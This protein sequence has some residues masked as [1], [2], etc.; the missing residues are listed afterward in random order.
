MGLRHYSKLARGVSVFHLIVYSLRWLSF[1]VVF[2]E[3]PQR[4]C[5]TFHLTSVAYPCTCIHRPH[6]NIPN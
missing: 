1:Y 3:Y 6:L 2:C 5:D 4:S